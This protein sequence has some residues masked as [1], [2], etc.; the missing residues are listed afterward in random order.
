MTST[1]L[2]VLQP[3]CENHM[4]LLKKNIK[5]NLLEVWVNRLTEADYDEFLQYRKYDIM[6]GL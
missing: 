4:R 1:D 5:I 2:T 3:Y 6:A